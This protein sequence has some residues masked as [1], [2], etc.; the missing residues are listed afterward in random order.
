MGDLI[1]IRGRKYGNLFSLVPSANNACTTTKIWRSQ[2]KSVRTG[3]AWLTTNSTPQADGW[4][5]KRSMRNTE[6][7]K[8]TINPQ[9]KGV[10]KYYRRKVLP[11]STLVPN[12]PTTEDFSS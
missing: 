1:S 6:K 5:T 9:Y 12:A 10:V 11:I 2:P 3:S 7:T 4:G 8:H